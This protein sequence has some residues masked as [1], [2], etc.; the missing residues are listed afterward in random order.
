MEN[1]TQMHHPWRQEKTFRSAIACH[2]EALLLKAAGPEGLMPLLV[3]ETPCRLR[4]A[5]P[6]EKRYRLMPKQNG[7]WGTAYWDAM[8]EWAKRFSRCTWE[9]MGGSA[10]IET[11]D[12]ACFL[13]EEGSG[14]VLCAVPG[15]WH[16]G[17]P[18]ENMASLLAWGIRKKMISPEAMERL[19]RQAAA[20]YSISPQDLA[21][22]V[23]EKEA[24]QRRRQTLQP[25]LDATTAVLLAGGQS[26]RMGT[27]KHRLTL[28]G[29]PFWEHTLYALRSFPQAAVSVAEFQEE[30]AGRL[31]Q[32]K[33][34]QVGLGPISGLEK[35]L[36][37]AQTPF[38]LLVPC[39]TPF[40]C[41]DVLLYLMAQWEEGYDCLV[42]QEK[43]HL[44]PL[45]G[46][47]SVRMLPAVQQA[48]QQGKRCMAAVLDAVRTKKVAIPSEWEDAVRNLNTPEEYENALCIHAR[49]QKREEEK[50]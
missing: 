47:Y 34:E 18:W 37:T 5:L 23:R 21:E 7:L 3:E 22:T 43:A 20:A 8:V 24:E 27:P 44:N 4:I 48:K 17:R 14:S 25:R 49:Q 46:I 9:T 36:M 10:V 11:L 28:D 12:P 16:T 38:V 19:Q 40:L 39:D 45:I 26:S 33:D 15:P 32:W 35:A 13:W 2:R 29:F 6:S 42:V 31:S 41:Q 50:T 30:F 1:V